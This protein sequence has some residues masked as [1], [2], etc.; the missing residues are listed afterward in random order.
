MEGLLLPPSRVIESIAETEA[1]CSKGEDPKDSG[2][3]FGGEAT[4]HAEDI[5][6]V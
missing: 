5:N 3:Q 1:W 6:S 2:V 4:L